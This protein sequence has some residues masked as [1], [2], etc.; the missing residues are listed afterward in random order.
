[1]GWFRSKTV[2]LFLVS[3]LMVVLCCVSCEAPVAYILVLVPCDF[4]P[5][6]TNHLCSSHKLRPLQMSH[7]L[8]SD[9]LLCSEALLLGRTSDRPQCIAPPSVSFLPLSLQY[10][11][12]IQ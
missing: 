2:S 11:F 4:S 6:L 1:M 5:V 3:Q 10:F 12:W 7:S 8:N 9:L